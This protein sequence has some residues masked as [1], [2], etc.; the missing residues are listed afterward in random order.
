M[1]TLSAAL[2]AGDEEEARR[3][4]DAVTADGELDRMLLEVLSYKD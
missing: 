1:C 4:T 3:I 2:S